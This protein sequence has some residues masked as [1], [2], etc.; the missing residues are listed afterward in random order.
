MKDVW[1]TDAV[2]VITAFQLLCNVLEGIEGM[3]GIEAFMSLATASFYFSVMSGS[4]AVAATFFRRQI[5]R[6][7]VL[8]LMSAFADLDFP[9][10]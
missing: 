1:E 3:R 5:G 8:N 9:A 4:R 6:R 10:C 2:F 7:F